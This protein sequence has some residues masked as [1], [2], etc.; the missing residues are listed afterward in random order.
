MY[1]VRLRI[2]SF[3]ANLAKSHEKL[4]TWIYTF[5][6][7]LLKL[8][9][10]IGIAI[11]IKMYILNNLANT[12]NRVILNNLA[13]TTNMDIYTFYHFLL[14]ISC[15]IGIAIHIKMYILNNLVNTF[16]RVRSQENIK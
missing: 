7:F 12:F 11:H 16:N 15:F 3:N 8:S 6:H 1:L 5:Y 14:K 2:F 13:K 10:F 9:C 4:Q